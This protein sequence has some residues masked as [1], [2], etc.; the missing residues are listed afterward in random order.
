MGRLDKSQTPELFALPYWNPFWNRAH[1][2][3]P[4]SAQ[5]STLPKTQ[6]PTTPAP[7]NLFHCDIKH[8]S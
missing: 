8:L 2:L 6:L 3:L 4:Y 1:D 5:F 7:N